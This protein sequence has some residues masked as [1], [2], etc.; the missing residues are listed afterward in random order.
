MEYAF[1]QMLMQYG[2]IEEGVEVTA[3][4]RDRYDGA[5]RNPWN[6]IEC[7][8]NYARSMA[9]W[10]AMVLLAG[11]TFDA[12]RGHVGFAPKVRSGERLP[13]L[14]VGTRRLG[15]WSKSARARSPCPCWAAASRSLQPGPARRTGGR[16]AVQVQRALSQVPF[17]RRRTR[18]PRRAPAQRRRRLDR[19]RTVHLPRRR[20]RYRRSVIV[21]N[22]MGGAD[23]TSG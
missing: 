4:V 22:K 1:A 14:L 7:G 3:A 10:G 20:A 9:S 13:L 17:G 23:Q 12:A 11:F 5:K 6:E 15:R 16:L 8:S 21:M 2:M 19:R 18:L